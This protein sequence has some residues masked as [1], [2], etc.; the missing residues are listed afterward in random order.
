MKYYA[1]NVYG[2]VT[3][4][5]FRIEFLNEKREYEDGWFFESDAMAI[6][7]PTAAKKLSEFLAEAIKD[8]EMEHGKIPVKFSKEKKY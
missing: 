2:A 1:T 6:L 7:S 4:Q 3:T 8:Y 5:D